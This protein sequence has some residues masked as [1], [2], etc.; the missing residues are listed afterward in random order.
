VG[1][2]VETCRISVPLNDDDDDN[3]NNNNNNNNG[4]KIHENVSLFVW[5]YFSYTLVKHFLLEFLH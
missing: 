1:T 5:S 4:D 3:N 2:M